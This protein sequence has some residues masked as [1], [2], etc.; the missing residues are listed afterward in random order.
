MDLSSGYP[1]WLIQDGL[2]FNYPKLEAS[3]E[4]EVAVLGGGISGALVAYYLEK[5]GIQCIVVDARSIGLGSTCASTALLQY[6]I[7]TPLS[8]LKDLVGKDNAGRAYTL[9]GEAIDKLAEIAKEI[10]LPAFEYKESLYYAA[11]GKDAAFLKKELAARKE[12]GFDVAFMEKAEI[13]DEF[14]FSAPAG[15]LSTQAAQTNAYLFTHYLHQYLLKRG[16]QVYD[17]TPVKRIHHEKNRVILRMENGCTLTA[18]KLVY[19]TGYEAVNFIDKKVVA[20]QS[21]Y[22]VISEQVNEA[23]AFWRNN[24]LLW[25]T[26][27]PYLYLRSVSDRRIIIGGRDEQFYN[28]V[29]R[30]SL[31][32]RKTKQLV[33]DFHKLFPSISFKPEFSWTGT[34]GATKDGLPFIGPYPALPNSFFALGF[35]GNGITFSQIAGEMLADVIS[36]QKNKDAPLFSFKRI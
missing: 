9:C 33:K 24:A 27:D 2:L 35:G 7:D 18:K 3:L 31:M 21:T 11:A 1:F 29:R 22:A 25:N 4:T 34:F 5:R 23:K 19:A 32:A 14:G 10:K 16:A 30:D 12:A 15:I 6:E 26:A 20:L 28:P 36:G 8:E 17:R 13:E